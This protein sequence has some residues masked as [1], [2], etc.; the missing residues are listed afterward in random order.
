MRTYKHNHNVVYSCLYHVI[1]TPKYRR[2]LLVNRVDVRLKELTYELATSLRCELLALEVM[3]DHVHILVEVDPQFGVTTFV[4]RLKGVTSRR[5]RQE[6]PHLR[7]L[8]SL[9]TNSYFVST[10]GAV[11]SEVVRHYIE[12][13]KDQA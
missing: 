8:P 4:Q 13:Q 1:F 10:T 7:R 2:K 9:W 3:P 6:F 11:E 5:L 12:T